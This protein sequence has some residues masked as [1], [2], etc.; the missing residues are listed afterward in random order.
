MKNIKTNGAIWICRIA[1]TIVTVIGFVITALSLTGCDNGST[2]ASEPIVYIAGSYAKALSDNYRACYW[3]DEERID[4]TMGATSQSSSATAITVVDGSV[5]VAGIY[6]T[7]QEQIPCYWKDG[8]KID[9]PMETTVGNTT[10]IAVADG[11]IYVVGNASGPC[12]WKDGVRTDLLASYDSR[13]YAIAI[14]EGSV[15]VTG[16]YHS[17]WTD[18][19]NRIRNI[20]EAA[21][22]WK[23]GEIIDLYTIETVTSAGSTYYLSRPCAYAIAIADGSVYI[24]G[25][26]SDGAWLWRNGEPMELPNR[27]NISLD[28]IAISGGSVY[29]A[30]SVNKRSPFYG[31]IGK[32]TFTYLPDETKSDNSYVNAI[33]ISGDSVY[34]VGRSYNRG[35]FCI[36]DVVTYRSTGNFSTDK[37]YFND[38]VVVQ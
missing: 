38:I 20:K 29:Y 12:Y 18:Y 33:A 24:A 22:Y 2:T 15:Y 26:Y 28:A 25:S 27:S 11:S 4:L 31:Q 32:S 19:Q 7:G 21:C 17:S 37:N 1:I 23:D 8:E 16:Y 30:G 13:A 14:A 35:W 5:Y 34:T 10:G 3:K 36:N 6:H 9:L